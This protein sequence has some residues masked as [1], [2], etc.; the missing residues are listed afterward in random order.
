MNSEFSTKRRPDGV[1][2]TAKQVIDSLPDSATMDDVIH[3]LYI[4]VKFAH[5]EKEIRNGSGISHEDAKRE[6]QKW[7]K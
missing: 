7:L 5:G 2:D 6:L 3:A 4:S 1:K